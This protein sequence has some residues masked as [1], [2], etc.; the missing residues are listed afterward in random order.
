MITWTRQSHSSVATIGRLGKLEVWYDSLMPKGS[1][2][3]RWTATVL[4]HRLKVRFTDE[5]AAKRMAEVV[6][7]QLVEE[8]YRSLNQE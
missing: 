1:D 2:G 7:R 3:P 4:G 6:C 5:E 8:A